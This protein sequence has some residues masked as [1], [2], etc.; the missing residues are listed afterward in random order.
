[1]SSMEA[2]VNA[3][4]AAKRESAGASAGPVPDVPSGND[5]VLASHTGRPTPA[6]HVA[7]GATPPPRPGQ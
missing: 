7:A 2:Q 4:L 3:H 1:V 5:E 6:E